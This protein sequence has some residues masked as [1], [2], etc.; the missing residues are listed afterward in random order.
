MRRPAVLQY[1]KSWT[2]RGRGSSAALPRQPGQGPGPSAEPGFTMCQLDRL[3][4]MLACDGDAASSE[5]HA[6]FLGA[7]DRAI[8]EMASPRE[9]RKRSLAS[10]SFRPYRESSE[11]AGDR[12]GRS[13]SGPRPRPA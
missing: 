11:A 13:R 12:R 1:L 7:V 8:A 9:R 3:G 4:E 6:R 10:G 5:R 2:G